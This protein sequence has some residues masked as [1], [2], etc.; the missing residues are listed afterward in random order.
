MKVNKKHYAPPQASIISVQSECMLATTKMV[1]NANNSEST[2]E[3]SGGPSTG[4]SFTVGGILGD[5]D[6]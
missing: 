3:P 1:G 2:Q 5:S 6:E 4:G